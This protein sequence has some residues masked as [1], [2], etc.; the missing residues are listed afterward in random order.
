MVDAH[1]IVQLRHG[2][3]AIHPEAVAMQ[4][5][6]VPAVQGIAPKLAVLAEVIGRYARHALGAALTVELEEL[7]VGPYVRGILGHIDGHV[8]QHHH[9][10]LVGVAAQAHPL[11]AEQELQE[12]VVA[13]ILAQLLLVAVHGF[14]AAHADVL[15][16]P[17]HPG[18]LVELLLD[19]HEQR[20]IAQPGPL[21]LPYLKRAVAEQAIAAVLIGAAQPGF[22]FGAQGFKIRPAGL[23]MRR[24]LIIGQIAVLLQQGQVDHI[25]I[26]RQR[27]GALIGRFAVAGGAYRQHLP[28]AH[29]CALQKIHKAIGRFA[30]RAGALRPGQRGDMQQHA[31]A[32]HVCLFHCLQSLLRKLP[33]FVPV[34]LYEKCKDVKKN[35]KKRA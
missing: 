18:Y 12:H 28:D 22:L 9:P 15:V 19:C 21:L 5:Q 7:G 25:G 31:A 27:A 6:I 17:L 26:A 4:A 35:C 2:A 29:A 14:G 20:V 16:G 8:A 23:S 30:Q 34:I 10:M 13:H 33:T 11:I 24:R 32:A 3:Q 1:A